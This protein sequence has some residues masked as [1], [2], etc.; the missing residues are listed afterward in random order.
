MPFPYEVDFAEVEGD[1]DTYVDAVFAVLESGFL[2]RPKGDGFIEFPVFDGGY[3]ALKTATRGF[4]SVAANR[5]VRVV[6]EKPISLI[7]LRC[8]LGFTPPEWAYHAS[9]NVGVEV[10]QRSA[11]AIDRSIRLAPETPI[12]ERAVL[13]RRRIEALV[14]SACELLRSGVG[15]GVA[16]DM[17]HRLDK[18]DTRQGLDSV[19][20]VAR[21]GV[22]YSVL[23]YERLLGRPFASHRDSVSELVGNIVENAVEDQ[24]AKHGVSGRKTKQ[25]ERLPGFDQTPDFI[26]PNEYNPKVVIEAKLA[27]D[28]GTARDKVTRIQHL[29]ELS[30]SGGRTPR[31]EVVGCIAGRGF[32][33][34]REDMRKLILATRGKLFTLRNMQD[35]VGRTRLRE[36]RSS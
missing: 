2:V 30:T 16:E 22:P 5:V 35:L 23:L 20:A 32:A 7:V 1:L 12:S 3:E 6:M 25:A 34:R 11:R 29:A 10:P 31:F 9:E 18:A 36:F 28:E 8:M 17:I 14:T 33:V 4:R 21:L 13:K 26:A 27:E 15:N 24:L 19:S